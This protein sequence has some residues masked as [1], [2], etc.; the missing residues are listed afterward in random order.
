MEIQTKKNEN[1]RLFCFVC[2]FFFCSVYETDAALSCFC[3]EIVLEGFSKKSRRSCDWWLLLLWWS[4]HVDCFYSSQ[5][6]NR[7]SHIFFCVCR[8]KETTKVKSNK[9]WTKTVFFVFFVRGGIEIG[10]WSSPNGVHHHSRLHRVMF[11]FDCWRSPYKKSC[12]LLD[13]CRIIK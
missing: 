4:T 11:N 6:V 5:G 8:L 1:T 12:R 7:F 2:C 13:S 10:R 9:N 3:P